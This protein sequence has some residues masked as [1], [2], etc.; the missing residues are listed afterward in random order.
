MDI[1][2]SRRGK[3]VVNTLDSGATFQCRMICSRRTV[4][5][6]LTSPTFPDRLLVQ[7][8]RSNFLEFRKSLLGWHISHLES[9][10][11]SLADKCM[12]D[13]CQNEMGSTVCM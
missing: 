8:E 11:V 13:G 2:N 4:R 3:S 1:F 10:D 9:F 5:T 12:P 6:C 7:S